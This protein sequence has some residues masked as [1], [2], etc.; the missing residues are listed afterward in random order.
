MKRAFI[1]LITVL[2]V[3]LV[4]PATMPSAKSPS[5]LDSPHKFIVTGQ[6]G[7]FFPDNPDGSGDG[8]GDQGDADDIGG[9]K[10]GGKFVPDRSQ[11]SPMS[12][13]KVW[14]MY[15]LFAYRIY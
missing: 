5:S 9:M 6:D 11:F 15:F 14:W 1:V 12:A 3:V 4:Y 2:A 8:D 7:K 13:A 10:D